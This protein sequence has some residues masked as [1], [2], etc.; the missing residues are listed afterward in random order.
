MLHVF[1][2]PINR[3]DVLL[4]NPRR[5]QLQIFNLKQVLLH[6]NRILYFVGDDGQ[7]V[8]CRQPVYIHYVNIGYTLTSPHIYNRERCWKSTIVQ[9]RVVVARDTTQMWVIISLY[10]LLIEVHAAK[11]QLFVKQKM[12]CYRHA[13]H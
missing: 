11:K 3:R 4:R 2:L 13:T 5:N 12:H 6:M 8:Q 7:C 10:A 1:P 9:S